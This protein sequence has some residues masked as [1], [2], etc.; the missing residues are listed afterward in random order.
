MRVKFGC[1]YGAVRINWSL[2]NAT[3]VVRI[4]SPPVAPYR[5]LF[6]YMIRRMGDFAIVRPVSGFMAI[7]KLTK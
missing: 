7:S 4:A 1:N 5:A 6:R 2:S 3:I